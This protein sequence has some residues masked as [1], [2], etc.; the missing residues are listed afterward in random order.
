MFHQAVEKKSGETEP[1]LVL[2]ERAKGY[3]LNGR[4][5][6]P[7]M[8]VVSTNDEVDKEASGT[9][10]VTKKNQKN[11]KSQKNNAEEM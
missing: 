5:V 4:L 2:E 7:S 9:K 8:V 3:I 1:D 10:D 6:R 11:R